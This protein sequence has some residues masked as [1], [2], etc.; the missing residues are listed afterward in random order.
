MSDRPWIISPDRLATLLGRLKV[1]RQFQEAGYDLGD[2]IA[3]QDAEIVRLLCE[4]KEQRSD[5]QTLTSALGYSKA[6]NTSIGEEC[7]SLR[8]IVDRLPKTA[9]GVAI[10]PADDVWVLDSKHGCPKGVY[11]IQCMVSTIDDAGPEL[12]FHGKRY[13]IKH[14]DDCYS[15]REA[16][17][18]A[19]RE[20]D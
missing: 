18:S 14:G 20:G 10:L 2:H 15:T 4:L 13:G 7:A 1:H 19:K 5:I 9:D 6:D 17:E 8:A 16:A 12:V 3:A 11:A